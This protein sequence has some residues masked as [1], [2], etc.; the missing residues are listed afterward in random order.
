MIP[1][2]PHQTHDLFATPPNYHSDPIWGCDPWFGNPCSKGL[3][4]VWISKSAV[5]YSLQMNHKLYFLGEVF[6]C[7][8]YIIP[9]QNHKFDVKLQIMTFDLIDYNNVHIKSKNLFKANIIVKSQFQKHKKANLFRD[10]LIFL[11]IPIWYRA[12][13]EFG[14]PRIKQNLI[15]PTDC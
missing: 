8:V 4:A 14:P 9:V 5:L 7:N 10:P 6:T 12:Q 3:T 1:Q 15:F 13:S 11:R 2:R